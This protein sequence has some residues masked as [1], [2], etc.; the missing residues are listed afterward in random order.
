[1][2]EPPTTT[3]TTEPKP[4]AA[5]PWGC[6]LSLILLFLLW[7]SFFW[8]PALVLQLSSVLWLALLVAGGLLLRSGRHRL[9]KA[10]L[11]GVGFTVAAIALLILAMTI[12]I[13]VVDFQF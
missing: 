13:A 7:A 2:S 1:M 5:W 9:G 3:T 10:L 12:C 4:P 11:F 8:K 6:L